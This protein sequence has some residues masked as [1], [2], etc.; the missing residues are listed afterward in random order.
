MKISTGNFFI[1]LRKDMDELLKSSQLLVFL[2]VCIFFSILSPVTARYMPEI[3]AMFGETQNIIITIPEAT[4]RDSLLQYIQNFSQIGIMVIIFLLMGSISREKEQGTM[5][6]LLVKPVSRSQILLSKTASAYILMFIGIAAAMLLT[7]IYTKILFSEIP[8][9]AFIKGNMYLL[10]YYMTVAAVTLAASS[11]CRKPFTSAVA[12]L[13]IWMIAAAAGSIPIVGK[14]SFSKLA[15]Q[16]MLAFDSFPQQMHSV[17]GAVF[18]I[19]A[20]LSLG[21]AALNRWE[22]TD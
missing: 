8:A 4:Y 20:A 13:G 11:I 3:L 1:L 9:A 5:S 14:F 22:P 10:L 16:A 17:V 12:A 18:V 15:E 19:L 21:I 2:A 7:G 6:F